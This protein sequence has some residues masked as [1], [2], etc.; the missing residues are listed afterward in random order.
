VSI[1]SISGLTAIVPVTA[2]TAPIAPGD[3]SSAA[4]TATVGGAGF[5][6][7]LAGAVDNLQQVQAK[8]D[9]LALEA[10]TG[11]LKNPQDYLLA[12]SESSLTTQLTVAIRNKAIEAFNDIMRM[13][14]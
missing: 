9:T 4:A 2:P 1:S 11:Q 10:A 13:P 5:S 14:V 6:H 3:A 8:S 7:S 12:A